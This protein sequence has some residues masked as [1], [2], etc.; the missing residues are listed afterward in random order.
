MRDGPRGKD[1][2]HGNRL[3]DLRERGG[4]YMDML[5][6]ILIVLLLLFLLGGGYGYRA[7]GRRRL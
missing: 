5:V 7:R 2:P 4:V 3:T 1:D 6:I